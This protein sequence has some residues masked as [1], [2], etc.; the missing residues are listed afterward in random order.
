VSATVLAFP[1]RE[2]GGRVLTVGAWLYSHIPAS[3]TDAL[4]VVRIE[5]STGPQVYD[6]LGGMRALPRTRVYVRGDGGLVEEERERLRIEVGPWFADVQAPIAGD[7]RDVDQAKILRRCL[8]ECVGVKA[9]ITVRRYS[10]ASG[11]SLAP[12]GS[13][14]WTDE[15]AR[16][17]ASIFPGLAWPTSRYDRETGESREVWCVDSSMYPRA[18]ED[19]SDSMS[20]YHCP[21]GFR[22]APAFLMDVSRIIGDAA[23]G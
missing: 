6:V 9:S 3:D 18:H 12:A 23:K 16:R 7:L 15:E 1:S 22:V 8:R 11:L 10:M 13:D 14:R 20:D 17:I 19:R 5:G 4:V 21:G 2:F